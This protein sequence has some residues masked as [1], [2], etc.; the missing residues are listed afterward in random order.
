MIHIQDVTQIRRIIVR[1]SQKDKSHGSD[2][3]KHIVTADQWG[4][5]RIWGFSSIWLPTMAIAI[6]ILYSIV[7][8]GYAY[9]LY[10][11]KIH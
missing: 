5:P 3:L 8:R 9:C 7:I 1:R 2:K 4:S 11:M 10:M 6:V